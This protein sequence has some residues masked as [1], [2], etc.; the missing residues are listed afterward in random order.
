ML[1]TQSLRFFDCTSFRSEWHD[2]C[3]LVYSFCHPEH[4]RGIS[5]YACWLW[6]KHCLIKSDQSTAKRDFAF[7]REKRIRLQV[8][9]FSS[10]K[11][12]LKVVMSDGLRCFDYAQHDISSV[13]NYIVHNND[14]LFYMNISNLCYNYE[15]SSRMCRLLIF[16]YFFEKTLDKCKKSG[17]IKSKVK[18]SQKFWLYHKMLW[19]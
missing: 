14:N 4:S 1:N 17:I 15:I 9:W 12:A 6:L 13:C 10:K 7:G 16:W 11:I 5:D 18:E 19:G 2:Q 8:S 3:H